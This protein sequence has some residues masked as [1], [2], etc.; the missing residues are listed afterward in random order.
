MINNRNYAL[1]VLKTIGLFAIVIAHC[2]N[3]PAIVDYLRNFE[4][5]LMV[6]VSGELMCSRG[7]VFINLLKHISGNALSELLCQHGLF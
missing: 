3:T 5:V 1:D 4:V 6:L 2:H 7:G